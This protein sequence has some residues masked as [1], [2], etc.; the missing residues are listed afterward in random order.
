MTFTLETV[1]SALNV[2][3]ELAEEEVALPL[4]DAE[5]PRGV[6]ID[7]AGR[8]V[9]V[10]RPCETSTNVIS[11]NFEFRAQSSVAIRGQGVIES[12]SI[13][14][15]DRPRLEVFDIDA[16]ATVFLGLLEVSG[17]V[18]VVLSDVIEALSELFDNGRF[19]AIPV[20]DQIGLAGEL[21]VVSQA[22]DLDFAVKCWRSGDR[23]KFD[24]SNHAERIEIKTTTLN[25][26]IH[27]FNDGQIPGPAD[28]AVVVGSVLLKKVE[29]GVSIVDLVNKI[30]SQLS[31]SS[32]R[33]ELIKKAGVVLGSQS[34]HRDLIQFDL[35]SS[36]SSILFV[37]ATDV[38]RPVQTAGVLSMNWSALVEYQNE[39]SVG[40][41]LIPVICRPTG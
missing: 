36:L 12:A 18:Q 8:V 3:H 27:N 37:N 26:R 14:F 5:G 31:S 34:D 33:A 25:Q 9:L 24:F 22:L 4:W 40:S 2:R 41:Q 20:H 10:M 29:S 28:C 15:V 16:I 11:D 35:E 13:L 19:T 32:A 17:D 21:L 30:W 23:D 39:L 6:G 38:P 1:R 7:S